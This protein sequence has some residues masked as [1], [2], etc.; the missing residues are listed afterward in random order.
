MPHFVS[1]DLHIDESVSTNIESGGIPIG[2]FIYDV[3]HELRNTV[4]PDIGA[5]EFNGIDIVD[6]VEETITLSYEFILEQNYPNPFNP[7]T[8][9]RYT[10]PQV[11]ANVVKQ[12]QLV[13]LKVY[14]IL[15][16]E[17]LTL[18]NEDNPAGSYEVNFDAKGLSSGIYFYKLQAGSFVETKKM[19]LLK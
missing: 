5:D 19:I 13:T 9:I 12:S 8:K 6:G 1:P 2:G 17:V 15:G 10:I 18:V 3:E 7:S 4:T 14:D 11:I 16:N